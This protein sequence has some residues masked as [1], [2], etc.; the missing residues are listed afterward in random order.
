M[1]GRGG[2]T[3]PLGC[4]GINTAHQDDELQSDALRNVGVDAEY[5]HSDVVSTTRKRHR[6]GRAR[7]PAPFHGWLESERQARLEGA[8]L[9]GRDI[10]CVRETPVSEL[11][12]EV[13]IVTAIEGVMMN[14]RISTTRADLAGVI[15]SGSVGAVALVSMFALGVLVTDATDPAA[16]GSIASIAWGLSASVMLLAWAVLLWFVARVWGVRSGE[17]VRARWTCGLFAYSLPALALALYLFGTG[18]AITERPPLVDVASVMLGIT[19][20]A[21]LIGGCVVGLT[22]TPTTPSRA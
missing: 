17:R 21:A 14:G 1:L 2:R 16:Y 18:I 3:A 7:P 6:R 5:I 9:R 8:T 12:S 19:G 11:P 20:V 13:G 22:R 10:A 15:I 4:T